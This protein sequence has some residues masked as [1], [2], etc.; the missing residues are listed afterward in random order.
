MATKKRSS[1]SSAGGS[2]KKHK[3]PRKPAVSRPSLPLA[4]GGSLSDLLAHPAS[5]FVSRFVGVDRGLKRLSLLTVGDVQLERGPVARVGEPVEEA[6]RRAKDA[7]WEWVLVLDRDQKPLGWTRVEQ[8]TS[9]QALRPEHVDASSPL[10]H[11]ETTLRDALSMMLTS[12]VQTAVVVDERDR[13]LGV[14]TIGE[15]GQAFRSEEPEPRP[16]RVA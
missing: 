11:F 10:V 12:A 14:L 4:P 6:S 1:R 13:Y 8:L 5:D 3:R 16:A 15:L 9:D 7:N 2:A